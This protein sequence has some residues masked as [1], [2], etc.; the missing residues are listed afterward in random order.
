M[1]ALIYSYLKLFRTQRGTM[2]KSKSQRI[3][4]DRAVAER[5]NALL[6]IYGGLVQ[7]VVDEG[8]ELTGL[9]ALLEVDEC[10]MTLRARFPAGYMIAF[11]G[12]ADLAGCFVK[13]VKDARRGR[14]AWRLDKYRNDANLDSE[15]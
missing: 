11:V 8:G 2:N 5:E 1:G 7:A 10:L 3:I 6:S 12:A 14:L 9:S 13:A 4:E 15:D